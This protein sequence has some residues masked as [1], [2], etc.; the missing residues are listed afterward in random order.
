MHPSNPFWLG[1]LETNRSGIGLLPPVL[2]ADAKRAPTTEWE[3][4]NTLTKQHTHAQK[5]P[6]HGKDD[7]RQ[8]DEKKKGPTPGRG[9]NFL[10]STFARGVRD[11]VIGRR[12]RR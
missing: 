3:G 11:R 4:E 12:A 10:H 5:K 1:R 7:Q 8:T 2:L 6:P 9:N